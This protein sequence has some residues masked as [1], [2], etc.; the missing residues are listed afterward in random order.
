MHNELD[1]LTKSTIDLWNNAETKLIYERF[2]NGVHERFKT[3]FSLVDP[4][5]PIIHSIKLRTKS[6]NSLRD[7]IARKYKENKYTNTSQFFDVFNDL[8]GI[9]ILLLF[10]SH[11]EEI[12]Q[13]INKVN[14]DD[15]KLSEE[16]K[17]YTW[18]PANKALFESFGLKTELKESSYTS[19]HYVV[20]PNKTANFPSCEIQVRSLFEE[21]WGE[22]DHK[23]NYPYKTDLL[24]C[25]EKLLALS[26]LISAGAKLADSIYS[27]YKRSKI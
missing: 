13:F 15:W 10:H 14:G 2:L 8:I 19:V 21:I 1:I 24:D 20:M 11:V 12:H 16:P 3:E 6:E 25:Q 9:R 23:I 4:S 22:I 5:N 17:A 27:S 7:K 26:R 18:D